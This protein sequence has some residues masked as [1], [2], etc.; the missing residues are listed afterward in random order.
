[1]SKK[2]N[3]QYIEEKLWLEIE[4]TTSTINPYQFKTVSRCSESIKKT[5]I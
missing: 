4:E 2:I 1:M 5:L 3:L